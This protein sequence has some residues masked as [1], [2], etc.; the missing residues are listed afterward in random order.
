MK[1]IV[2]LPFLFLSAFLVCA[3]DVM[4]SYIE[5]DE[6][7]VQEFVFHEAEYLSDLHERYTGDWVEEYIS[8][9]IKYTV[10]G[11]TISAKGENNSLSSSQKG[12]LNSIEA[13]GTIEVIVNYLPK[14]SLS[15]NSPKSMDYTFNII[16]NTI[17]QFEGGEESFT[18]YIE[19]NFVSKLDTS[20]INQLKF[21][22]VGLT[23]SEEGKIEDIQMEES[24][25][26]IELDARLSQ[27]ICDMPQWNP[28]VT[29][30]GKSVPYNLKFYI[31][32][33]TNSC[34]INSIVSRKG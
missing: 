18:A 19:T 32:N 12:M 27:V 33:V 28:A 1:T 8:T 26:N 34:M 14:N 7:D 11:Q 24:T 4:Y 9:E 6:F 30:K 13:N 3:Q 25:G 23:I 15:S 29:S 31:T 10:K 20:E 21:S 5:K 17:P 16:P 22:V 2:L